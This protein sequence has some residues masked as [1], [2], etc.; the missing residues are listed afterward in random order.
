MCGRKQEQTRK[1]LT[2]PT[3]SSVAIAVMACLS[4][5]TQSAVGQ[6]PTLAQVRP[7]AGQLLEQQRD[8]VPPPARPGSEVMPREEQPRPAMRGSATL[9]V[10][11]KQFQIT[12]NRIYSEA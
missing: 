11:V 5:F 12:G 9:K 1:R 10:T 8:R 6:V 4:V 2:L 3:Q 7:D